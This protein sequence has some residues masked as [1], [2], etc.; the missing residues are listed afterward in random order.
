M[1]IS[2]LPPWFIIDV[3]GVKDDARLSPDKMSMTGGEAKVL[4]QIERHGQK[5]G[6]FVVG[7]LQKVAFENGLVATP[8]DELGEVLTTI[9]KQNAITATEMLA[10]AALYGVT[11]DEMRQGMAKGL[12]DGR[13]EAVIGY[14]RLGS[15]LS[16]IE[17]LEGALVVL[18]N[19]KTRQSVGAE[20]IEVMRRVEA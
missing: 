18:A 5:M 19:R 10:V 14:A 11:P 1:P 9:Q 3:P 13:G 7:R 2:I 12:A 8:D 17:S 20:A 15:A 4:E 16:L 6:A